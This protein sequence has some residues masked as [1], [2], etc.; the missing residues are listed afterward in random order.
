MGAMPKLTP[1]HGG[2]NRSEMVPFVPQSAGRILDVGCSFGLF[3]KSLRGAG[4]RAH[5]TGIEP[6]P[7]AADAATAH[8]DRVIVGLFPDDMPGE[9]FD[10]IV[11]NDV[12]EHMP[13]PWAALAASANYLTTDGR[14]IASIPN[15]RYIAVLLRLVVKGRWD[16]ADSGVLDVSHLRFF[17][18]SSIEDLFRGE[19]FEIE[20]MEPFNPL[21]RRGA[22]LLFRGPFRDMRFMNFA[23]VAKPSQTH[24]GIDKRG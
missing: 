4:H 7:A 2:T 9:T 21:V 22:S 24:A 8:Y 20:R 12:L 19:G 14:V 13:D 1:R 6:S 23:V 10:C 16:Y 17:T 11:M 18:R 15:V 3:G 5:L